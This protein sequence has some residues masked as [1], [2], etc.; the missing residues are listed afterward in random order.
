MPIAPK[1]VRRAAELLDVIG[2]TGYLKVTAGVVSFDTPSVATYLSNA[3]DVSSTSTTPQ[4]IFTIPI[5]ANTRYAIEASIFI[6]ATTDVAA[7]VAKGGYSLS[8]TYPSGSTEMDANF[9]ESYYD[10]T[11]GQV[12]YD[13]SAIDFPNNY[14]ASGAVFA[15]GDGSGNTVFG[16]IALWIGFA[17]TTA[18][19]IVIKGCQATVNATATKFRKTSWAF[20]QA[21]T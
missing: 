5:A 9:R 12:N 14:G 3:A 20:Y 16:S 10:S 13:F 11:V 1:I 8:I 15:Q 17:S 2:Q 21:L 6:L 18:G 19:N 4:T 7:P